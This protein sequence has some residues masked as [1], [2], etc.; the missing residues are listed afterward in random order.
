[1]ILD[2]IDAAVER[3][4]GLRFS[5]TGNLLRYL[6]ACQAARAAGEPVSFT[7]DPT[8]LL[9]QAI[10]RRAGWLDDPS[11]SRGSC[12][13]TERGRYPRRAAGDAQRH[14]HHLARK[15]NTPRLAVRLQECGE[16][17]DLLQA[18]IRPDRW[19]E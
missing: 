4:G 6:R 19:S 15:L 10:N 14:L 2:Q 12:R 13:P 9:D 17:R 1:M 8:W 11:H 5:S 16:H 3:K 7:T 18:R